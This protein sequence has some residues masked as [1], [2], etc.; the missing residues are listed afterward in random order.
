[1]A[2]REAVSAEAAQAI[3]A[4]IV[5]AAADLPP[6]AWATVRWEKDGTVSGLLKIGCRAFRHRSEPAGS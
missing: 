6:Q 3:L 4:R 2:A 1:M 5:A